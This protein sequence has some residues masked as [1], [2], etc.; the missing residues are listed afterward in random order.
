MSALL[1]PA[2]F[3]RANSPDTYDAVYMSRPP[4]RADYSACAADIAIG[5]MRVLVVRDGYGWR[6]L[7]HIVRKH[8]SAAAVNGDIA[9]V[10]AEVC[11]G[12]NKS[13]T[14][15]KF[16]LTVENLATV[17]DKAVWNTD[18]F[19]PNARVAVGMIKC[20]ANA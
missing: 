18:S 7:V 15:G 20:A 19:D 9:V 5:K 10:C 4:L 1:I 11:I 13:F 6:G 16:D 3:M 14:V 17:K 2:A 12:N 8:D